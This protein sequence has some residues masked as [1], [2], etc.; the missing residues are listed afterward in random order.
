MDQECTHRTSDK[1]RERE[2]GIR[3]ETS[4]SA[5]EIAENRQPRIE[6]E[7]TDQGFRALGSEKG[8]TRVTRVNQYV[9]AFISNH[10]SEIR[11]TRGETS[12]V[13]AKPRTATGEP[14]KAVSSGT[15]A[16]LDVL[17]S[18]LWW[19]ARKAGGRRANNFVSNRAT[20]EGVI[21]TRRLTTNKENEVPGGYQRQ[22]LWRIPGCNVSAD[23]KCG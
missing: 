15:D 1:K 19:G 18:P 7:S 9:T 16:R 3:L 14:A 23:R 13:G 8:L 2:T 10:N 6:G 17:S 11:R 21:L 20:I 22:K 12:E 5:A 4:T